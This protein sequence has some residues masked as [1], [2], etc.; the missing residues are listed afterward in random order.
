MT[1]RRARA[2]AVLGAAL[3]ASTVSACAGGTT[4]EGVEV[5]VLDVTTDDDFF[6]TVAVTNELDEPIWIHDYYGDEEVGRDGRSFRVVQ[7]FWGE[8]G[9]WTDGGPGGDPV[10]TL[11]PGE[12][13]I[14][15]WGTSADLEDLGVAAGAELVVCVELVTRTQVEDL[16][17]T[18]EYVETIELGSLGDAPRLA[19]S[20]P[21]PV[22]GD[23]G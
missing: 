6:Y 23:A 1:G 22:T 4:V 12:A 15:T 8:T 2:I 5:V 9:P 20:E 11:D 16:G 3:A 18:F 19:C 17:Q 14:T 21:V 13:S 10:V 7:A